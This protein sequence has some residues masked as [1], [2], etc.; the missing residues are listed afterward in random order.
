[1]SVDTFLGSGRQY[2]WVGADET[3]GETLGERDAQLE[4]STM[5]AGPPAADA[6]ELAPASLSAASETSE[7]QASESQLQHTHAVALSG[8]DD[9]AAAPR[10]I[11]DSKASFDEN[12]KDLT[13]IYQA[14]RPSLISQ[15][16]R[17]SQAQTTGLEYASTR[18][19]SQ[20]YVPRR[21]AAAPEPTFFRSSLMTAEQRGSMDWPAAP[22][23]AAAPAPVS[24]R[25]VACRAGAPWSPARRGA[26]RAAPRAPE[27]P[28]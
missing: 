3:G 27:K 1:M 12:F 28:R 17:Q 20:A 11:F 23:M 2:A 18:R 10:P 21:A 19:P 15:G 14:L 5:F 24:R 6:Q 9:G 4:P 8:P 22:P 13:G 26:A 7:S 25:T 16:R